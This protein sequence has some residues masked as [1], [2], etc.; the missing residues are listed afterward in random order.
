MQ[1]TDQTPQ[2]ETNR[3]LFFISDAHL[4]HRTAKCEAA[5][6]DS[7]ISF[8]RAVKG[9]AGGLYVVGDLFDFWFEYG[10][11]VPRR[12]ARVLSAM[13]ELVD[14]GVSVTCFGGNHDWWLGD[15]LTE[16]FGIVVRRHPLWLDAQGQRLYIAHGDGLSSP[17]RMYRLIRAVLHN[18]LAGKAFRFLHP[19]VGAFLARAVSR[20]HGKGEYSENIEGQLAPVY[21]AAAP[22]VF[23]RGATIAVFGHVQTARI[24]TYGGG[25]VA[26]LGEWM[27]LRTYGELRE[28][29]FALRSWRGQVL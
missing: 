5:K 15:A 21:R 24:E 4:R 3:P 11:T 17:A 22:Q 29:V 7:L 27:N 2:I 13:A 16:E 25:T 9:E 18:P 20:N 26:V 6:Q 12:G 19:A 28:G 23:A 1:T 14:A 8:L 10:S